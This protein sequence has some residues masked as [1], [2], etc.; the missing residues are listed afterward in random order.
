MSAYTIKAMMI[1]AVNAPTTYPV[2]GLANASLNVDLVLSANKS[3]ARANGVN[4]RLDNARV[5][6]N[7]MLFYP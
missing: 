2:N 6:A 3:W 5:V 1:I 4:N 7:F